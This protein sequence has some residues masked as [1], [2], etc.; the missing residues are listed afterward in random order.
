MTSTQTGA[1]PGVT[2]LKTSKIS[3]F[4]LRGRPG[5]FA[6]LAD[7]AKQTAAVLAHSITPPRGARAHET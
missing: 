2:R 7:A 4:D 6:F 3:V 1:T 5:F